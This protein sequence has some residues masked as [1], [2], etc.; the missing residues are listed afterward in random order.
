MSHKR[1]QLLAKV[2]MAAYLWTDPKVGDEI[3]FPPV[4]KGFFREFLTVE[5]VCLSRL[6][7]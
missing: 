1:V 4:P 6:K 2:C 7:E 5:I 3:T